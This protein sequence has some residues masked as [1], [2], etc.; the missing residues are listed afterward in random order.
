MYSHIKRELWRELGDSSSR[1]ALHPA[2]GRSRSFASSAL[3]KGGFA[4]A[5]RGAGRARCSPGCSLGYQELQK[6]QIRAIHTGS[7]LSAFARLITSGREAVT[8]AGSNLFPKE[9]CPPR[10]CVYPHRCGSQLLETRSLLL[11]FGAQNSIPSRSPRLVRLQ[12]SSPGSQFRARSGGSVAQQQ[13]CPSRVPLRPCRGGTCWASLAAADDGLH[14]ASSLLPGS[15]WGKVSARKNQTGW[16]RKQEE[17]REQ[18]G[19]IPGLRVSGL[20]VQTRGAAR[21]ARDGWPGSVPT[22]GARPACNVVP[23]ERAASAAAVVVEANPF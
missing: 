3:V 6:Q 5:P 20:P 8:P 13:P 2:M 17:A 12:Q 10:A 4:S 16:V 9:S 21:T 18:L 19:L 14:P 23:Q 7:F 1:T 11:V 22:P 15:L